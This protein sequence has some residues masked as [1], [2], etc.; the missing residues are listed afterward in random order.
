M[1]NGQKVDVRR[2]RMIGTTDM[3]QFISM[4]WDCVLDIDYYEAGVAAHGYPAHYVVRVTRP[5]LE[6][7]EGL[8]KNE[9]HLRASQEGKPIIGHVGGSDITKQIT[10]QG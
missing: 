7:V 2:I 4:Y 1:Q 5:P 6:F 3:F 10:G 9:E 8:R